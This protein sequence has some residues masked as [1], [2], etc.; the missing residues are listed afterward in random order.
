MPAPMPPPPSPPVSPHVLDGILTDRNG[1]NI[2]A[3][4]NVIVIDETH[5][6]TRA[7]PIKTN[8][9]IVTSLAN[10]SDDWAF[11]DNIRIQCIDRKGNGE[12]WH[13]SPVAATGHT[14]ITKTIRAMNPALGKRLDKFPLRSVVKL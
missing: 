1:N 7:D 13:I 8:G 11:G 12:V 6:G 14:D 10:V 5:A 2:V 3:D 9:E 4:T